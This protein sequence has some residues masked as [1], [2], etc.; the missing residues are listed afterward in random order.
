MDVITD[1]KTAALAKVLD[2]IDEFPR[3]AFGD[4]FWGEDCIEGNNQISFGGYGKTGL[5]GVLKENFVNADWEVFISNRD[6]ELQLDRQGSDICRGEI[7]NAGGQVAHF[8]A[9]FRAKYFEV[10]F[11]R[12]CCKGGFI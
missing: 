8:G 11:S 12:K 9:K 7:G 3:I 1:L 6:R 4:E 2:A 10:G 5:W